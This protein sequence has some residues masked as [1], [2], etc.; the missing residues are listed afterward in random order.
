M[1]IRSFRYAALTALP[2]VAGLLIALVV[3]FATRL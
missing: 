1:D 3:N 2:L